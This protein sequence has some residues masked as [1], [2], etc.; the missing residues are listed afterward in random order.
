MDW[1]GMDCYE[2]FD[3]CGGKS[4]PWY[5]EQIKKTMHSKQKLIAVP[6][7]GKPINSAK[8]ESQILNE[9]KKV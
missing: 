7:V 8:T 4:I 6:G 1:I 2:G 3:S 9:L 5:Y